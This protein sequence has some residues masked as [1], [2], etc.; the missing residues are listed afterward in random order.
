MNEKSKVLG[1][2]FE[3]LTD[4]EM[5]DVDG[6]TAEIS[7]ATL[8]SASSLPCGVGVSISTIV[9]TVSWIATHN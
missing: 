4:Q 3:D 8:A 5:M 2:A 7:A 6:G 1:C 9:V